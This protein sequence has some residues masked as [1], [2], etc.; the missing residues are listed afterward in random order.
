MSWLALYMKELRQTKTRFLINIVFLIIL[1][2][3]FFVL[4]ERYNAFF[5]TLTVPLILVHFVYMLV[6]MFDSLRLEWKQNT[7][8]FWLNIPKSGWQLIT[9]KFSA[10]MT[11]LFISLSLTFMILYIL[12]QRTIL[13]FPDTQVPLFILEQ[14]QSFWW[15]LFSGLFIASLQTGIVAT[16]I[17]LMAK[18]IRKWGWLLGIGIVF[19]SS[20][21]WMKFQ[22]T[23]VYRAIT[24]WGVVLNEEAFMNSFFVHFDGNEAMMDVDV[25]TD[26]ILYAGTA[27]VDI[28][29]VAG[30]LFIC[31]WLIDKKVEA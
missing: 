24:E 16:F 4:T 22:E 14:F 27:V 8:V 18:S 5:I 17:Y 9:A 15:I 28:L 23:A 20:W 3:L 26:A 30:V 1:G 19:G 13:H 7:A 2:I 25:T 29:V 12:L 6:A 10:A 11:Q 31:G 21:I